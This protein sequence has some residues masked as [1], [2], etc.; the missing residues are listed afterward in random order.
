[1]KY[2]ASIGCVALQPSFRL[3][4][5]HGFGNCLSKGKRCN[6]FQAHTAEKRGRAGRRFA[7][8]SLAPG[9]AGLHVTVP[10]GASH[11]YGVALKIDGEAIV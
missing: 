7:A 1:M 9:P 6:D 2:H 5:G 3:A 10:V 4:A 11:P 8:D